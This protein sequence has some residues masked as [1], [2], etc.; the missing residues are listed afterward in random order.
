MMEVPH[1]PD[2]KP[3]E[4]SDREIIRE[5]LWAFQPVTSELTFTN[6]FM[7]RTYYRFTWCMHGENLLIAGDV[8]NNPFGL[9]PAGRTSRVESTRELLKWFQHNSGSARCTLERC[10]FSLAR[11]CSDR[12]G[13]IIE[14][15]PEHFDYVYSSDKLI[16]LTGRAYHAK[17]NHIQQFTR[18]HPFEYREIDVDLIGQCRELSDEWCRRRNCA[19]NERLRAEWKAAREALD[20]FEELEL[21]GG[22]L[23]IDGVVEAFSAGELLNEKTAVIHMEKASSKYHGLY[24]LINQRFSEHE[25]SS[26]PFINREQDLGEPGLRKAKQSYFPEKMEKKY[27]ISLAS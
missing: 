14:E 10:D 7:W 2:F 25:W 6:I 11:E 24:T 1:F 18:E 19:G 27:R 4:F 23:L 20:H 15:T 12:G 5:R 21:T 26:V 13:F 8:L 16:H 17:R 9:Q 22:A 3:V